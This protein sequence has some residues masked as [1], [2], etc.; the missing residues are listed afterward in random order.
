M[1]DKYE[2]APFYSTL[3]HLRK[4]NKALAANAAFKKLTTA[5]DFAIY[6]FVRQKGKQQVAVILNLSDQPQHF[7]IKENEIYGSVKDVFTGQKET[8]NENHVYSME[9]WGFLVYEF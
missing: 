7:T 1:W 6:A 4:K 2:M 5:N 3:L 8:L 9:P